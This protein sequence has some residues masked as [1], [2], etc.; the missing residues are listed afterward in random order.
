MIVNEGYKDIDNN[1][2]P[3]Y[4]GDCKTIKVCLSVEAYVQVWVKNNY[5]N[6]DDK[7]EDIEEQ[8][9]DLNERELFEDIKC[10]NIE[11]WQII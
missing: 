1:I 6:E 2:E 9:N 10:K 5:K 4:D 11:D 7:R 8:L 3:I